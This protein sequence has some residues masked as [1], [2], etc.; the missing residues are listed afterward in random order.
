[1]RIH[2]EEVAIHADVRESPALS[3][4]ADQA[5]L[6]DWVSAIASPPRA[7]YLVHGEPAARES[8]AAEL[9]SRYGWNVVLP[10]EGNAVE[11]K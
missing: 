7:T 11:L 8:L 2:G 5:G 4:H 9:R 10:D 6:V 3:A 1:V